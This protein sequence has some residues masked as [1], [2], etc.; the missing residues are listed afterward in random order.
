MGP[1]WIEKWGINYEI[2]CQKPGD[3]LVTLLGR[4]Y[5]E[6][7]NTG[8]NFAAAINYEFADAPDDPADY[9][10]SEKGERKCG[11]NVLTR[12]SFMPDVANQAMDSDDGTPPLTNKRKQQGDDSHRTSCKRPELLSVSSVSPELSRLTELTL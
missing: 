3:V 9:V 8:K 7:R 1:R 10:W 11:R 6:V 4:V 12:Q 5:H 2:V